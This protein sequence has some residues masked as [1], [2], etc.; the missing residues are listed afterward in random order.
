[1]NHLDIEFK[2]TGY[3]TFQNLSQFSY[4]YPLD[5]IQINRY[6]SDCSAW[7]RDLTE[8]VFPPSSILFR[9]ELPRCFFD[10]DFF[11]VRVLALD[12]ESSRSLAVSVLSVESIDFISLNPSS[13]SATLDSAVFSNS[14]FA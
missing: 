6:P 4:D 14:S 9:A 11:D 7:I 13:A 5:K 1:M 2:N 3:S 8:I 12:S 10:F